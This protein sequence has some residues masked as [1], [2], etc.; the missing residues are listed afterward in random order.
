MKLER[1]KDWWLNRARRE[2]NAVIGAGLLAF[3]PAPEER[4]ATAPAEDSRIAFGKFV[5]E[6]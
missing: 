6:G 5:I 3:D 4:A 1:S 2:G